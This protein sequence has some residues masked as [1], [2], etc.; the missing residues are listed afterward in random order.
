M[1]VAIIVIWAVFWAGWLIAAF[2][3]KPSEPSPS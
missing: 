2:D 3:A 1:D